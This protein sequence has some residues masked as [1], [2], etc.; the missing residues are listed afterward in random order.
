MALST[1]PLVTTCR[2]RVSF[3]R[4][5]VL[6]D[7]DGTL[8]ENV[9]YN[10]D[11]ARMRLAPGAAEALRLLGA[12]DMPLV[13][14]SNQPGVALGYFAEEALQ[15]VRKRLA[16]LFAAHGAQ[17]AGFLYCPH[18]PDGTEPTLRCHCACRKPGAGLLYRAAAQ[19][20]LTLEDSWMVG[21]I[22]DD[23][24]AG[25]AVNCHTILVDCGSETEWRLDAERQPDYTVEQLDVAAQLIAWHR[26]AAT[27]LAGRLRRTA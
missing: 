27:G 11:P 24:A 13:V 7:K 4:P 10:V 15:G 17:L 18:H 19:F 16:E 23:V 21:D 6:L 20:G 1:R 14:V 8:L 26:Q 3:H 12:L 5:A 22:L 2:R 25:N 9:P